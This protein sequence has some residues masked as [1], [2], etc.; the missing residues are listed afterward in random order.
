MRRWLALTALVGVAAA[1][2]PPDRHPRD[3]REAFTAADQTWANRI[4]LKR[5]DLPAGWR[6]S[7]AATGDDPR[8][9]TFDP[10]MSDLTMTGK[11]ESL[12]FRRGLANMASE[13]Q[14]FRTAREAATSFRRGAK[15]QLIRCYDDLVQKEL[16]S[17]A[18]VRLVSGRV[19]AAPPVG[20]R[21]FALSL[22]W[23]IT[24]GPRTLR[25]YFDVFGWDRGRASTAVAY[26]TLDEPPDRALEV[27]IAKRL[28][29]R[30]RR[31]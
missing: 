2:G 29:A 17:Q 15:P 24:A 28:D 21:R 14:I 30:M 1:P 3:P 8:C 4:A 6:G 7:R 19:V 18:Q 23:E 12:D 26:S 11:A 27:R 22:V 10:D 16:G 25:T 20:E 9:P 5:S 13:T 31:P